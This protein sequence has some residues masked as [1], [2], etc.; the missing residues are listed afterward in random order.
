MFLKTTMIHLLL[1]LCS[2]KKTLLLGPYQTSQR[3]LMVN[4]NIAFKGNK[5]AFYKNLNF[6]I[7]T[8]FLE[9][10]SVLTALAEL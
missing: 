2:L 4:G 9:R 7:H 6:F 8:Y 5:Y 3:N 10:L 1:H